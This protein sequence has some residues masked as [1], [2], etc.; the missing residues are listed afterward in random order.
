VRKVLTTASG[1]EIGGVEIAAAD[2]VVTIYG[3]VDEPSEK[4]GDSRARNRRRAVR[5]QPSGRDSR[6]LTRER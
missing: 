1:M 2:G 3:T 5:G 4:D 6:L